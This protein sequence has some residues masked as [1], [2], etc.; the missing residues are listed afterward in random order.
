MKKSLNHPTTGNIMCDQDV[1]RNLTV[2]EQFEMS[3]SMILKLFD[4]KETNKKQYMTVVLYIL[5]KNFLT[6]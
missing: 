3:S 6:R 1:P 5:V 2:D 4:T